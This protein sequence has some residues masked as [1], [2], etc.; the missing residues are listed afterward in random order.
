VDPP[1]SREKACA[2]WVAHVARPN[3]VEQ[4]GRRRFTSAS[5]PTAAATPHDHTW[6][7][8]GTAAAA[9]EVQKQRWKVERGSYLLLSVKPFLF[10]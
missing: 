1:K 9:L 10:L 2:E 6:D 5:G 7:R 3:K 8:G 4:T